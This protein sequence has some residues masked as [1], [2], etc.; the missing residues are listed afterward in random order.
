M[1][2][3]VG[4][5]IWVCIVTLAAVYASI[6]M[7]NAPPKAEKADEKLELEAVKG[8]LN[9]IPVFRDGAVIGYFLVKL[10]YE[11]DKAKLEKAVT[12]VP[13]MITDELFT[14]LVGDKIID[15]ANTKD[16]KLDAFKAHI[17]EVINKR[18]GEELVHNVNVEQ[19]DYISKDDLA[20]RQGPVPIADENGKPLVEHKAEIPGEKEARPAKH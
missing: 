13:V 11:A 10:S 14:S 16:F 8:D 9:S 20:N 17:A 1:I 18:A 12:P 15:I 7:A 19:L 4:T 3:L 2:K 5:G 6:S